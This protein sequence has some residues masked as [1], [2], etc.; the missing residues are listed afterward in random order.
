VLT[1]ALAAVLSSLC[2]GLVLVLP[3]EP[4][5]DDAVH[6]TSFNRPPAALLDEKPALTLPAGSQLSGWTPLI[7]AAS[8]DQLELMEILLDGG[9]DIEK[10]AAEG[11]TALGWA[12]GY[13]SEAAAALLLRR[14]ACAEPA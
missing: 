12:L 2:W 11:P 8:K 3:G 6:C 14:G 13:G 1:F 5:F 4:C 9:A 10:R 7:Q